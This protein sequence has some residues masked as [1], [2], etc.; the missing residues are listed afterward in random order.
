MDSARPIA[1]RAAGQPTHD[2]GT[3]FTFAM[4]TVAKAEGFALDWLGSR[5]RHESREA[6]HPLATGYRHLA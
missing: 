1:P 2:A 3:T 5:P 6:H 4:R